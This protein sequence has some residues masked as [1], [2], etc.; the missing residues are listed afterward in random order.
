MK[1]YGKILIFYIT[2]LFAIC[3]FI[4]ASLQGFFISNINGIEDMIETFFLTGFVTVML[5]FII[6]MQL[7]FKLVCIILQVIAVCIKKEE[8]KETL[9]KTSI[10]V[11]LVVSILSCILYFFNIYYISTL[12]D[13]ISFYM[14]LFVDVVDIILS[15]IIIIKLNKSKTSTKIDLYN[16]E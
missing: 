12:I 1:K 4:I 9:C 11:N 2:M 6:I 15:S 16:L 5:G 3:G 14:I 7:G 10:I 8:A 13:S